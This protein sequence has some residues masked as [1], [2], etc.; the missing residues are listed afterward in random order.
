MKYI[1]HILP[2]FI[3]GALSFS[4]MDKNDFEFSYPKRNKT[5]ITAKLDNF[6]KF[7]K[8]WRGTDYYYYGIS[9]DSIICSVLYYK[10]N[11]TEQKQYVDIFGG[12]TNA[13]IP[14]AY[15]SENSNLKKYEVNVENWG[16]WE[17][18]FMFRQNDITEYEGIKIHQ[19]HMYAYT[20]FDKDLFVIV[21][22]SKT[23]Y[24]SSD[25]IS[26][27]MMLDNFKKK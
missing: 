9:T 12:M 15:F 25:S 22:L 14:F 1:K 7:D 19:K 11:E 20:M 13:A 27:R 23:N 8:E 18:D 4:T 2:L 21:H 10:L 24:S 5:T 26:M 17:D 16:K 3:F 6:K